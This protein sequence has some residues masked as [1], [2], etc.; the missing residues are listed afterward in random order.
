MNGLGAIYEV[1]S[2]EYDE[3]DPDVITRKAGSAVRLDGMSWTTRTPRAAQLASGL[4]NEHLND[5]NELHRQ[6]LQLATAATRLMAQDR[7]DMVH[8]LREASE[9]FEG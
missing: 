4:I 2:D 3:R 8:E 6:A 5:P 7:D 1:W 9:R